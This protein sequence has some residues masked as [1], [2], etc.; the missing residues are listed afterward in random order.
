MG[1][2]ANDNSSPSSAY[3]PAA[4]YTVDVLTKYKYSDQLE[5]SLG[6][7]NLFNEKYYQYQNVPYN[8]TAAKIEQYREPGTSFQAQFKFTF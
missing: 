1:K 5:F 8:V 6:I 4:Y 3:D 7:N 2:V